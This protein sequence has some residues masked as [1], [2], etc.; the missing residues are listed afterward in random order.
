MITYPPPAPHLQ[1]GT[2]QQEDELHLHQGLEK[3]AE[4]VLPAP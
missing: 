2:E 1:Q 3:E 4:K